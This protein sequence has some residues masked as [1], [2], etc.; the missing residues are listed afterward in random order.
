MNE[1]QKTEM[2]A[3]LDGLMGTIS[4]NV[5]KMAEFYEIVLGNAIEKEKIIE[6]LNGKIKELEAKILE[7]EKKE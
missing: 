1:V 5:T 6:D 3:N 2:P 7:L 4:K